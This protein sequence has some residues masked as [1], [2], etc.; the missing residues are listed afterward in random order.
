MIKSVT[1]CIESSNYS[2]ERS[3]EESWLGSIMSIIPVFKK[4]NHDWY[5]LEG[6]LDY[7]EF[8]DT[9]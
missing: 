8:Q 4:L 9:V 5:K 2:E 1:R 7:K 6:S 3:G